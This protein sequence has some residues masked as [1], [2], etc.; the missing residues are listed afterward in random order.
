MNSSITSHNSRRQWIQQS[1]G[2]IGFAGVAFPRAFGALSQGDTFP[3]LSEIGLEGTV[4]D[5][6]GKVVLVDFWASW[7]G[8]CKKAFPVLKELHETY[9]A[10]GL[11]IVAVSLD[12]EKKNMDAFLQKN[13]VPFAVLRDPGAKL[14]EKLSVQNIPTSYVLDSKGKVHSVHIGFEGESTR[15]K[16]MDEIGALLNAGKN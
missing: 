14:A 10:K 9:S 3:S 12:E 1:L 15:K 5:L 4:P 7:C 2:L 16:Y 8:P 6:S 13:P 11:V